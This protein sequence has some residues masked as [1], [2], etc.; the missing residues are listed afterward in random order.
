MTPSR[1]SGIREALEE[2]RVESE[3]RARELLALMG[4]L[5]R[6]RVRY[7]SKLDETALVCARLVVAEKLLEMDDVELA[8][9]VARDDDDALPVASDEE[10]D[11]RI[12]RL[13]GLPVVGG[14]G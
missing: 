2:V 14:A 7:W 11:V 13:R 10:I 5:P 1:G 12:A 9:R 4:R 6:E 8:A 3:A